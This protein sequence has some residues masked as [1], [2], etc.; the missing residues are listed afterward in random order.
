MF[1]PFKKRYNAEE[2]E[3]FN[4][5]SQIKQ[6]EKLT[7]DELALFIPYMYLRKY[8]QNEVVF[9]SG[10][11]SHALYIIK[12]GRVSLSIDIKD[13]F[14]QLSNITM[15]HSFGDNTFLD[16]TKRIYNAMVTSEQAE[17][18]VIPQI[19]I[20]EI[21]INHPEIKGKIMASMAEL[22]NQYTSNIFKEYRSNF[23]FFQLSSVYDNNP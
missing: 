23:G 15:G 22:Y 4:F 16:G 21:L 9:F 7:N 18:Y 17:L 8:K 13:G 14:E 1:N 20:F 5:L 11:P 10:D 12:D 19:N 2:Q 3:Y 6:F